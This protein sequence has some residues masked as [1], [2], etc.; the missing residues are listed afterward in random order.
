MTALMVLMDLGFGLGAPSHVAP[1]SQVKPGESQ[2]NAA[3]MVG[4]M[5]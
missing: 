5:V 2:V 3:G 4:A 1:E